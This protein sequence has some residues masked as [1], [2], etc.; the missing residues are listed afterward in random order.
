MTDELANDG[1]EFGAVRETSPTVR[2]RPDSDR[3]YAVVPVGKPAAGDLAIFVEL[4]VWRELIDHARHDT[5]VELGGV[6]LGGCYVDDQQRP[7]VVVTDSL[8]AEHYEATRGSFKFTH[9]TWES[10]T[11]RRDEFNAE[12]QMVGWYHTHPDWGVFLSSL[13][14]FICDHFFAKPQ[15][16]ALVLDPCRAEWGWFQWTGVKGQPPRR[17]SGFYLIAARPRQVELTNLAKAF[18]LNGERTMPTDDRWS[19]LPTNAAGSPAPVVH[20]H[21]PPAPSSSRDLP[22]WIFVA[23]QTLLVAAIAWR[24]TT[25]P[26][27]SRSVAGE[28]FD[29]ASKDEMLGQRMAVERAE[30]RRAA[31]TELMDDVLTKLAEAPAGTFGRLTELRD[32]NEELTESLRSQQSRQREVESQQAEQM[33]EAAR[34]RR[35]LEKKIAALDQ[36]QTRLEEQLATSQRKLDEATK[37]L[38]EVDPESELAGDAT[39]PWYRSTWAI[40]SGAVLLLATIAVAWWNQQRRLDSAGAERAADSADVT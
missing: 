24:L 11:R 12:V 22:L 15:D 1:V 32:R 8:R 2:R 35:D 7:F 13:D 3:H 6:L 27:S 38:V 21:Q 4:D 18:E 25:T 39:A 10:I 17:T 31:Q 5:T 33:R 37:R 20:I 34:E 9:E 16:V 19:S 30:A 40:S 36:Q 29:A 28:R 14:T 23:L 26:D